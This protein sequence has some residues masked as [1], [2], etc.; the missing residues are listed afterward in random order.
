[1]KLN[2]N[3]VIDDCRFI[4]EMESIRKYNGILIKVTRGELPE[5]YNTALDEVRYLKTYGY[6]TGF[7]SMM[8]IKYPD[9][10]ISEWGWIDEKFDYDIEN[11][12]TVEELNNKIDNII[13][14]ITI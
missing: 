12:G 10:H 2:N 4:N 5:W 14:N 9:V 6:E 7:E 8:A 1:M 13:K 11:N 3:I